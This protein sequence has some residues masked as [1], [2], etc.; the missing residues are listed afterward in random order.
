MAKNPAN[1][2]TQF[3][4]AFKRIA[5]TSELDDVLACTA[6]LANRSLDEV[7]K[8]ATAKFQIPAQGVWYLTEAMVAELMAHYGF[9]AGT[10]QEAT[11][12]GALPDLCLLLLDWRENTA[13]WGRHVLF[14]RNR[15][16]AGVEYLIDPHPATPADKQV[17]VD[18]SDLPLPL[19]YIGLKPMKGG[20]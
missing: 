10:W 11:K 20:K 15:D 6:M 2:N 4:A 19:Y 16:G 12:P 3:Q 14:H 9:I 17:R 13:A 7:R 5:Q 18:L 1:G 8:V